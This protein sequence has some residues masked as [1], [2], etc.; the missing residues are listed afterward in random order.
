MSRIPS[1]DR[2][3]KALQ[4]SLKDLQGEKL[5]QK[6]L[7]EIDSALSHLEDISQA[8]STGEQHSRLAALY[9][10]SQALGTSL[11]LDEVLNQVMDAVIG[12]TRAERGFLMLVEEESDEIVVR[13]GRNMEQETLQ[14]E[15][16]KF[17]RTVIRTVLKTGE[18]VVTTNAQ[19]DPRFS[20]QDSVIALALRAILCA[21]LRVRGEIIGVIYV[22]NRAQAGLFTQGDLEM[23]NAFAS[24]AAAAIENA[25]V[26]TR[27]DRNLADRVEELESLARFARQVNRHESLAEVLE[28]TRTWVLEGTSASEVWIALLDREG[29]GENISV[30]IGP[31]K[32][33]ILSPQHPLLKPVLEGNTPHIFEPQQ[34]APA[35]LAVPIMGAK[36]P[37]G[38]L[39]AESERAFPKEDLQFLV[40]L[41]NQVAVAI[42]KVSLYDRVSASNLEKAKFVSIVSHE[43]RTP[44]TSI[45]GYTDLLKQGGLGEVNEKQM[46]FLS[47]IRKNVGRMSTLISDLSDIYKVESGRLHLEPIALPMRAMVERTLESLPEELASKNH[48][49]T[50]RIPEDLPK[51]Y[52]DPSRV[53]QI[54][55]YLIDNAIRYSP[56]NSQIEISGKIDGESVHVAVKD[57]G[58][59][60]SEADQSQLFTQFFRSERNEVREEQG[61]GLGLSVV[62]NLVE[63]MGGEVG[64]ESRLDR[65]STFWFTLPTKE[66]GRPLT[67]S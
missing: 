46:D 19:T 32:G 17:S 40:R 31:G 38:V 47:V 30:A 54:L 43:L 22:D 27:T 34:D 8:L 11:N 66:F 26:Y 29:S 41:A 59:G 24:Q 58:L 3:L 23:L 5:P 42:D 57:Q 61:W 35:R 56:E 10:V 21:P 65:G 28:S 63:L 48:N 60:I 51:V 14:K 52:A 50:I 33:E 64:F 62:K 12:L 1:T 44:M 18:G 67:S 25:R 20:G 9:R 15:D 55:K 13:M 6:V 49:I 4:A 16:M 45:M 7:A 39:V 53:E 2:N 37:I 36:A